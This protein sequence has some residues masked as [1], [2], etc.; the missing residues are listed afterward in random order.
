M[1]VIPETPADA[2][3][4]DRVEQHAMVLGRDE[5]DYPHEPSG[6]GWSW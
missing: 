5:D 4:A 1:S 3:E 2:D 6:V